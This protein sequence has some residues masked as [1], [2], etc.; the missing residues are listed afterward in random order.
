MSIHQLLIVRKS[1]ETRST[2]LHWAI[3]TALLIAVAVAIIWPMSN[4]AADTAENAITGRSAIGPRALADA[5]SPPINGHSNPPASVNPQASNDATLSALTIS[6]KNIIGF[7]SDRHSYEVGVASTV[8]QATVT[9][10]PNDPGASVSYSGTDADSN[11]AGHQVDL[12]A[13]RNTV[14]VTVTAEDTSTTKTYTVNVNQGVTD[15][16]GWKASDDLDGLIAKGNEFPTG[17][18]SNGTTMWVVDSGDAKLY[19]YNLDTKQRDADKD[20]DTL[21]ADNN[22]SPSG[23]WS[24]GTTMWVADI[25]DDK[26]YADRMSDKA[27]DASKDFDTLSAAGNNTP[28]GIWSNG[29][30]MW[31]A[32]TEDDKLYA[33]RMSD[34]GRDAGR[35]FNTL[36]AAGNGTPTGIWSNGT[37]MWVGDSEDD[38]LYSY[39]TPPPSDDATL[40]A[41]T[42]SP[43]DIIGFA[44]DR[45]SYEVGVASTVSQ[46]TVAATANYAGASVVITPADADSVTT[47]HQVALSGGRNTV[48]ITV[49]AEDTTTTA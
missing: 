34:K 14:T 3:A 18:W 37:T 47:G 45:D 42:L 38:K 26:L 32:D 5:V 6:P 23:I 15:P 10:T 9:A 43:K 27:R 44:S 1:P 11:T 20:F 25:G 24:N 21:I 30:T 48:T 39:N 4:A 28:V 17:I 35:D 33:Y 12:S 13:G 29:T 41:L 19:A 36:I 8:T 46:V 16:L 40:S 2:S 49:T 7:A 31:V 22:P